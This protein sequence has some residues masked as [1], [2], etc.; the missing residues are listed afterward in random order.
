MLAN[1]LQA[2]AAIILVF[3][4]IFYTI[5]T[6]SLSQIGKEPII[7]IKHP[8]ILNIRCDLEVDNISGFFAKDIVIKLKRQDKEI[9][10][11]GPKVLPPKKD[12]HYTATEAPLFRSFI[13]GD[14]LIIACKS[15]LGKKTTFIYSYEEKRMDIDRE[16]PAHFSLN[17]V[18]Q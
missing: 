18:F 1:W 4:T 12:G 8:S 5:Y 11:S 14:N 7:D 15:I 10:F 17:D 9:I 6:K 3:V 13:V 2:G 16:I